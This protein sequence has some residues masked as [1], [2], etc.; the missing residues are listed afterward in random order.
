MKYHS[1][2]YHL[3]A[4]IICGEIYTTLIF[5]IHFQKVC[6]D[7]MKTQAWRIPQSWKH[8]STQPAEAKIPVTFI[9]IARIEMWHIYP[10]VKMQSKPYTQLN[11]NLSVH[12]CSWYPLISTI[13]MPTDP[14]LP[15]TARMYSCYGLNSTKSLS[16][17]I[18]TTS[19][20]KQSIW[21]QC[22]IGKRLL[23]ML[24]STIKKISSIYSSHFALGLFLLIPF[25][26]F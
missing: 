13:Q 23:E 25:N 12:S 16:S 24:H 19:W 18:K 10:K 8:K 4:C 20:S 17:Y 26:L 11:M 5:Y 2:R 15:L 7:N 1:G 14:H 22:D 6:F 9:F 3:Y 21:I